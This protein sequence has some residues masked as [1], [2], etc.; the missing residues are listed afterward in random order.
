VRRC[1]TLLSLVFFF[2]CSITYGYAVVQKVT[3]SEEINWIRY[4]VPLPKSITITHKVVVPKGSVN[5]RIDG[6]SGIVISQAAK[7]LYTKS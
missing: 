6:G 2:V 7:E 5:V 3:K 1:T 4:T